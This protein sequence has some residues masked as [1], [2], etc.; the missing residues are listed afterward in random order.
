[1]C[2]YSELSDGWEINT[3]TTGASA[4]RVFV[5]DSDGPFTSLPNIYSKHP[6][7]SALVLK[8]YKKTKMGGNP[9]INKW[10]VSY[11]P[12]NTNDGGEEEEDPTEPADEFNAP[13]PSMRIGGELYPYEN[14]GGSIKWAGSADKVPGSVRLFKRVIMLD[15]TI[16]RETKSFSSYANGAA[17]L[18]GTVNG[19]NFFGWGAGHVLFNGAD[20]NP[21]ERPKEDFTGNFD[22][23]VL[24]A[25]YEVT[26]SFAIRV[27]VDSAGMYGWQHVYDPKAGTWKKTDPL[28]YK[29]APSFNALF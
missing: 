4:T 15:L 3:G 20:M 5:E 22:P 24:E 29:V 10:T 6:D 9:L 16:P 21:T 14:K 13:R 26:L 8:R 2:P 28:L 17:P 23:E 27:I 7:I 25:V 18:A 19:A 1:M 11:E 12:R